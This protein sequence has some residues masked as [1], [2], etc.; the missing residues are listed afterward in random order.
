MLHWESLVNA[1]GLER[2][3]QSVV[4][5]VF[6]RVAEVEVE[7][8]YQAFVRTARGEIVLP[9]YF[10][11]SFAEGGASSQ[12]EFPRRQQQTANAKTKQ[13]PQHHFFERVDDRHD[14]F[15]LKPKENL[16]K[17]HLYVTPRARLHRPVLAASIVDTAK[18][19]C[20]ALASI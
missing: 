17:P 9:T 16:D 10:S 4:V 18:S 14:H 7:I 13:R 12:S 1:V 19:R 6:G 20:C 15:W 2:F 8:T 5:I 11:G 3:F